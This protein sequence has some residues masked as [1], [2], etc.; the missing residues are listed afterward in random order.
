MT[1]NAEDPREMASLLRDSRR[2]LAELARR[3][4]GLVDS[5][6]ADG[7]LYQKL[8]A[9]HQQLQD[10]VRRGTNLQATRERGPR[11][12]SLPRPPADIEPLRHTLGTSQGKDDPEEVTRLQRM[13]AAYGLPVPTSGI[14]DQA[15]R[16]IV[17]Q[18]QSRHGLPANGIVGA[19]TRRAL[20][21]LMH[22]G[23]SQP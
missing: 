17:C 22:D 9:A 18:F 8:R 2:T 10:R 1:G 14:Y 12:G 3:M 16:A 23:A 13:L 21:T 6:Q 7:K 15:T 19:E 4:Q 11:P 5:G 20:N